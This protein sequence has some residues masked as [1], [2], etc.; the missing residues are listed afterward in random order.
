[1]EEVQGKAYTSALVF[2]GITNPSTG[3]GLKT[4]MNLG[5]DLLD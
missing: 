4:E 2:G 3:A 5:M 1:M